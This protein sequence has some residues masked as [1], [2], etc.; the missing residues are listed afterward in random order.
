[1]I[2]DEAHHFRNE[3]T[4]SSKIVSELCKSSEIRL[5]LTAPPIQNT[6]GELVTISN[7]ILP[8]FSREVIQAIVGQ[9]LGMNESSLFRPIMT[10]CTPT[11]NAATRVVNEHLVDM[12]D[13]ESSF[14]FEVFKTSREGN[15]AI[16]SEIS[17]MKMAASSILTLQDFTGHNLKLRDSKVEYLSLI[18][19]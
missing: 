19:I 6:V 2:A 11:T 10:R 14:V 9:A 13:E 12:N 15:S 17:K 5:I 16:L 18:H 7:L 1:M 3:R 4:Q 8:K